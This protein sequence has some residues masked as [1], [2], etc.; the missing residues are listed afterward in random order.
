[1]VQFYAENIFTGQFR[2]SPILSW[3]TTESIS[4]F[5]FKEETHSRHRMF[6]NDNDRFYVD[7]IDRRAYVDCIF[8]APLAEYHK[9]LKY[10]I[11]FLFSHA[12]Y[13]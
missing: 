6:V 9:P 10:R 2:I 1:M 3:R 12:I 7:R 4:L 8:L 5:T 11:L 13:R